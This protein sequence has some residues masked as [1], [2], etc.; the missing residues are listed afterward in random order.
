MLQAQV[1]DLTIVDGVVHQSGQSTDLDYWA[2][3]RTTSLDLSAIDHARPKQPGERR[4]A[5]QSLPRLDLSDRIA[6]TPFVQDLDVADALHGRPVHPPSMLSEIVSVDLAA[7]EARPGVEAVTRDGSFI[8]ILARREEDAIAAAKWAEGQIEWSTPPGIMEIPRDHIAGSDAALD[9]VHQ[10]GAVEGAEG[11]RFATEVSRPYL[12]HGSIGPSCALAK[13]DQDRLT[14]WSHTQGVFPLQ[15]A[16]SDVLAIPKSSID[17]VHVFGAGCYGHNGADDVALDAAL[18][19]RSAPGR[20]VRVQWSRANEFRVAP[21][22]PAMVTRADAVVDGDNRIVAM[23]VVANSPP[24]GN[25]PGNGT[26]NLRAAAYI[27]KPWPVPRSG[28]IPPANGGGADRNATPPYTIP[29]LKIAKRLVHDL[30]YRTSALRG[31]GAFTNVYAIETL[32]DDIALDLGLDPVAFRLSHLDDQRARAVITAT[33][34]LGGW[35]QRDRSDGVGYGFG[36]ARYKNTAAYCAVMVRVEVDADVR[37]TH[38]WSH[39]DTGEVINPDGVRNQIEG[40]IIQSASWTLK[41]AVQVA[42]GVV[43]STDWE[44]YP[45]LTFAEVPE[46]A[47]TVASQPDLALLGCGEASQG[48]TGAAIGNAVR[49]A[50]GVRIRDLPLNRDAIVSAIG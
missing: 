32:M 16:L 34:D 47:V 8:G 14:V 10:T 7:I 25:R 30:P 48:P 49:D 18:M 1:D 12:S 11:R 21:Q 24:H 44:A 26:P 6:G 40:G 38:A 2:L 31:L 39:V 22:G 29:N 17:V 13:W 28:D 4:L 46:I 50:L 41:E 19:A 33:A 20:V 36:Y 9:V 45:I 3:T 15:T 35:S 43:T 27:A 37:L 5:G 42:D 23:E